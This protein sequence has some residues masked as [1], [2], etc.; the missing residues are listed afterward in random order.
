MT[1][2]AFLII[3]VV[4]LFVLFLF[5]GLGFMMFGRSE[6]TAVNNLV[7]EGAIV[8][9][10]FDINGV[11]PDGATITLSQRLINSSGQTSVFE[12]GIIASDQT[13]WSFK[14]GTSGKSYEIMANIVSGG[15]VLAS[16]SPIYV[17]AP[18]GNEVLVF[19]I[20]DPNPT[21]ES[22][23]I[24]GTIVVN[25]YIPDGSTIA[26]KGRPIGDQ[27]FS[28]IAQA[29]P[30]QPQQFLSYA[31]AVAGETYE[32]VATLNTSDGDNI[33]TSSALTVAAPAL[34]ETLTI[35]STAVAPATPTATPTPS[36][37]PAATSAPAAPTATPT[38]AVISGSIDFN[39][40]APANSRIVIFQKV[41]NT[42]SYQVAVDNI[43]PSN[44]I[45]WQWTNPAPSTWYNLIAILKQRQSNNTD[46]DIASSPVVTV[47]APAANVQF[48]INSGI[49][50][51]SASGAITVTCQTYN[52][53]S[54]NW[55]VQVYFSPITNAQSYW[56]Q[57]GSTNGGSDNANS[58][59]S[60][61][62]QSL[63]GYS[64]VFNNNTTYYARY[65][66]GFVSNLPAG[67][68]QFSPFSGTTS[69][70]CSH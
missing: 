33:G 48:A 21:G 23:V 11:I 61:N 13:T 1:K 38:P 7:S 19:N 59:V 50:L 49:S 46:L 26:V 15:Q 51:P 57:I 64:S 5:A 14:K 65:A 55:N 56:F 40:Q 42:S 20:E 36:S 31:G 43:T 52:P 16:A 70:Q 22:A 25:G 2:R 35:N 54:N 24:S 45:T 12:S 6:K 34:N 66:Y 9:G 58:T 68:S 29:L 60:N 53:S 62:S 17:T 4:F 69:L 44:G 32:V 41:Y 18:A 28:T 39:G 67:S 30:G 37:Q 10:T 63:I 27:N 3:A 8:S 47:A